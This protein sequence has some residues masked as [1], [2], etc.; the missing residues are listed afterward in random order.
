MDLWCAQVFFLGDLIEDDV[1]ALDVAKRW[2]E[3]TMSGKDPGLVLQ[4]RAAG[5]VHEA[6]SSPTAYARI[7]RRA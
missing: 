5:N 6:G 4:W 1:S 7:F 2:A 3:A